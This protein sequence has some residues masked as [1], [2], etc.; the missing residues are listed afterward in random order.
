MGRESLKAPWLLAI[1]TTACAGVGSSMTPVAGP[2][3]GPSPTHSAAV[4]KP[5]VPTAER[6]GEEARAALT[7][8]DGTGAVLTYP[9]HLELVEMGLQPDVTVTWDG[10]WLMSPLVFRYG[11]PDKRLLDGTIEPVVHSRDDGTTASVWRSVPSPPG[12]ENRNVKRWLVFELSSWAVHVPVSA[13][14]SPAALMEAI[15]PQETSDGFVVI[16][17]RPPAAL[18][19]IS[20]EGGGPQ[21]TL[22]DLDPA[23]GIVRPDLTGRVIELTPDGC[24]DRVHHIGTSFGATC[25]AEGRVYLGVTSFSN[26]DDR[27]FIEA[28]VQGVDMTNVRSPG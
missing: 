18:S 19:E 17:T 7:F 27:T 9:L 16:G 22:G 25:L 13:T 28:V 4:H 6:V 11:G 12:Y 21:L 15:R 2:E 1:I 23:E 14:V 10:K 24:S 26:A 8:P 5:F 20:G 3:S